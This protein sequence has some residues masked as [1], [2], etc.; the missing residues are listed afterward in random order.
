MPI[1]RI[2][3]AADRKIG[4][5]IHSAKQTT[6]LK[7]YYGKR[8]G[9]PKVIPFSYF[10][11]TSFTASLCYCERVNNKY[12]EQYQTSLF[13]DV[14]YVVIHTNV[15]LYNNSSSNNNHNVV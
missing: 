9:K 6:L 11:K 12:S 15:L 8:Y 2:F 7:L 1:K 4:S 14:N 3:P 10:P 5:A 13:F